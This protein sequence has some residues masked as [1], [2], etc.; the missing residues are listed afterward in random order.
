MSPDVFQS[1]VTIVIIYPDGKSRKARPEPKV[2][3]IFNSC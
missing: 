3:F 2:I 1:H